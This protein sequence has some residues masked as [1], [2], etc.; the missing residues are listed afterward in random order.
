MMFIEQK[1]LTEMVVHGYNHSS[2]E[3]ETGES[4]QI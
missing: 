2:L 4:P 3:A 1:E